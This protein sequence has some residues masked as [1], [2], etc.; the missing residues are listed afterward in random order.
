MVLFQRLVSE[1]KRIHQCELM[2]ERDPDEFARMVEATR[3][4]H[5]IDVDPDAPWLD[6]KKEKEMQ[7][8]ALLKELAGREEG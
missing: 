6:K 3:V 1:A 2:E 7:L 5:M 8:K 4:N